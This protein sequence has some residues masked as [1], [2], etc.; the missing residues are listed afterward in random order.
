M[1]KISLLL[2]IIIFAFSFTAAGCGA[3]ENSDAT[4]KI[5][6]LKSSHILNETRQLHNITYEV[7]KYWKN[8]NSS[9]SIDFRSYVDS[10]ETDNTLTIAVSSNDNDKTEND[11]LTW[12]KNN[13][14]NDDGGI[15]CETKLIDTDVKAID[16][17]TKLIDKKDTSVTYFEYYI[18][19]KD[20]YKYVFEIFGKIEAKDEIHALLTN[21]VCSVKF[22]DNEDFTG[23]PHP[24]EIDGYARGDYDKY[25]SPAE[26]NGLGDTK[27]YVDGMITDVYKSSDMLF[28]TLK[29]E[30]GEWTIGFS[31]YEWAK[32]SEYSNKYEGKQC[33][34]MGKYL[35]YSEKFKKPILMIERIIIDGKTDE[36][37]EVDY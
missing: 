4:E 12:E 33:R 9:D 20:K 11:F 35:G 3:Q 13:Y 10:K 24:D 31:Y 5:K 14:K 6:P 21:M 37:N 17:A 28:G 18:W 27:V 25:N 29:A 1:K 15:F 7:N 30:S 26:E 22:N 8:N 23:E 32:E 16:Y 2:A 19:V 34:I 36:I